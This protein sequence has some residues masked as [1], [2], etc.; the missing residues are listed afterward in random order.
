MAEHARTVENGFVA[1]EQQV[2]GLSLSDQHPIEWIT[3]RHA[4]PSSTLGMFERD[5]QATKTLAQRV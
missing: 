3:V 1:D 2:L 5:G 4:Q